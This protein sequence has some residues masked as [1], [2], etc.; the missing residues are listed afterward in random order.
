M[1]A[2][3]V[4]ADARDK[5][6]PAGDGSPAGGPYRRHWEE[7]G[8]SYSQGWASPAKQALSRGELEFLG[9][10]VGRPEPARALDVGIGNGRILDHLLRRT[11]ATRFFGVDVAD[12]MVEVCRQS[13]AGEP[14]VQALA[15]CDLVHEPL[16]FEESFGF[17]SAVRVLKY[18]PRWTEALARLVDHLDEGG[19]MVFSVANRH[20]LN[21]V[22]RPY[23]VP[24]GTVSQAEVRAAC[25]SLGL[26][27]GE[28]AG[29]ARLPYRA[30]ELDAARWVPGA[31][32][33]VE[34]AL[35]RLLGGTRLTRE[36]FVA[37]TRR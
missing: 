28:V 27:V 15:R 10:H 34:R 3:D 25:A 11:S 37:A 22:S 1:V 13:F 23:A 30:Y 35:D 16:P 2:F 17:I 8:A 21:G 4:P 24:W 18:V 32:V 19:T 26:A 33:V 12:A 31:V 9:R 6:V 36:L 20:S 7:L 5:D 14:R 29:F